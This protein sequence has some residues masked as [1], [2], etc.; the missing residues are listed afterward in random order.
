MPFHNFTAPTSSEST[1]TTKFDNSTKNLGE[2]INLFLRSFVFTSQDSSDAKEQAAKKPQTRKLIT[3]TDNNNQQGQEPPGPFAPISLLVFV[4]SI[5][6]LQTTA[7]PKKNTKD[8][9]M[10][11][12]QL[13]LYRSIHHSK[14]KNGGSGGGALSDD[15]SALLSVDLSKDDCD[16]LMKKVDETEDETMSSSCSSDLALDRDNNNFVDNEKE[17]PRSRRRRVVCFTDKLVGHVIASPS[18]HDD[19]DD[20]KNSDNS[21]WWYTNADYERFQRYTARQAAL[22]R[23]AETAS[24]DFFFW[25]R[26]LWRIRQALGKQ[27]QLT[28]QFSRDNGSALST[29]SSSMLV[30]QSNRIIIDAHAVGLEWR[31][32]PALH[33]DYEERRQ[34]LLADVQHWQARAATA[35]PLSDRERLVIDDMIAD[36]SRRA[37]L[38]AVRYAHYI[39]KVHARSNS[40]DVGN[41]RRSMSTRTSMRTSLPS[42]QTTPTTS[43]R[44]LL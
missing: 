3:S 38:V 40:C 30:L 28:S 35:A 4:I 32:S 42:L 18:F 14:A 34:T 26:C 21:L 39:A 17:E 24:D 25:T 44:R 13:L 37:S 15:D 19:D 31:F 10:S 23:T 16:E 41:G 36:A 9:I 33:A 12:R 5:I 2:I 27:Q 11:T 43:T 29:S 22:L 6:T 7:S 20:N 1:T 8:Q